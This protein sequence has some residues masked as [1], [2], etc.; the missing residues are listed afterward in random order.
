MSSAAALRASASVRTEWSSRAPESQTGYQIRSAIAAMPPTPSCS[1]ST[2]RSL[3]GNCS[4]RPYPP[5]ATR[6]TPG[7]ADSRPASH[8]SASAVRRAR[9]AAN[10]VTMLNALPPAGGS[11]RVGAAF[12]GAYS[13]DGLDR[14]APDLAVPD[15]ARLGGLDD[16]PDQVVGI[17]VVAEHLEP[18]LGH[19]VDL[20][21][22]AAVD[23]GVTA[24]PAVSG[25]FR[26]GHAV[27]AERLQRALHVIELEW[28]DDCRD[29]LHA[30]T[31]SGPCLARYRPPSVDRAPAWFRWVRP[32]V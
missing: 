32:G 19:Q 30:T 20:V 10:D 11:E 12:S 7:S 15:P 9:S 31:S 6:A 8:R 21:L 1:R 16:H 22:G 4:R 3:P 2:S 26:H 25:R 5:T 13:D 28:L 23:L 29:E 24:L 17:L 14:H 27:H 18:G